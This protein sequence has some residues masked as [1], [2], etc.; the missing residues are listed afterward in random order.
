VRVNVKVTFTPTGGTAKSKSKTLVLE[1]APTTQPRSSSK[2]V[3]GLGL[4]PALAF[5][6]TSVWA[7]DW[8]A[9]NEIPHKPTH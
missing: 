7:T 2:R 4:D 8:P 5:G 1:S 3:I 9:T 6:E